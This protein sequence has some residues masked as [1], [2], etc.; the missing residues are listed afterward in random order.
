M[1]R[2]QCSLKKKLLKPKSHIELHILILKDFNTSLLPMDRSFRQ[3]L[4]I[5]MIKVTDDMN[6]MYLKI[7]TEHFTQTQKNI[8]S[9]QTLTEL[10]SRIEHICRH[11][12]SLK[13][14]KKIEVAPCILSD[15]DGLKL[16]FS[17][18]ETTESLQTHG[19]WTTSYSRKKY[20]KKSKTL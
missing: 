18:K 10:F 8:P 6:Q 5:K 2:H 9:S 11:K 3:K 13:R 14:W 17:N 4:N 1:Q 20:K 12:A 7:S 16:D 19:N 15:H